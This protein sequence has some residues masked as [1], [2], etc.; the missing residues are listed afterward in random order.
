MQLVP[1]GDETACGVRPDLVRWLTL[2]P[3]ATVMR[4]TGQRFDRIRE[5]N[6]NHSGIKCDLKTLVS[7]E[8]IDISGLFFV[9]NCKLKRLI[10]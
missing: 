9:E 3:P 4:P 5:R 7:C 2:T 10:G 6:A 8:K 1:P